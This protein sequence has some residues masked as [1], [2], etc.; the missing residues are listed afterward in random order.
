MPIVSLFNNVTAPRIAASLTK[1]SAGR[2]DFRVYSPHYFPPVL[3][4]EAH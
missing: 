2:D 4:E 1:S 3:F